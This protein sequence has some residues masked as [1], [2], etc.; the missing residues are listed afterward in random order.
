[1]YTHPHLR[2]GPSTTHRR[3]PKY[4]NFPPFN[5]ATTASL[6]VHMAT[7]VFPD[8]SNLG[9]QYGGSLSLCQLH[10]TSIDAPRHCTR[11][12]QPEIY[13]SFYVVADGPWQDIFNTFADFWVSSIS[14]KRPAIHLFFLSWEAAEE[15][16]LFLI[17]LRLVILDYT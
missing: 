17:I 10:P 1:M 5:I 16:Y 6:I 12:F 7:H 15:V 8:V 14:S 13:V 11:S 3:R 4:A 2:F 9:T